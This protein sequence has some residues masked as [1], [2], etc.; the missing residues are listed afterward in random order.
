MPAWRVSCCSGPQ[1]GLCPSLLI[2]AAR[3]SLQSPNRPEE[4]PRGPC[5]GPGVPLLRSNSCASQAPR[6]PWWSACGHVACPC[7]AA[8][9]CPHSGWNPPTL[10]SGLV[11]KEAVV[12]ASVL[13]L[14]C[15]LPEQP[16]QARCLRVDRLALPQTT[17]LGTCP[18]AASLSANGKSSAAELSP[19]LGTQPARHP[20]SPR[21]GWGGAGPVKRGPPWGQSY[22]VTTGQHVATRGELLAQP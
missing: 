20:V 12:R 17:T 14:P 19:F 7:G 21:A 8:L 10:P 18:P 2:A 16:L 5:A 13:A 9:Q 6:A 11:S 3:R 1:H 22:R 15:R 4:P